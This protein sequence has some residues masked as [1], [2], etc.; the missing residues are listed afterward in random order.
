VSTYDASAGASQRRATVEQLL[1]D[2]GIHLDDYGL[3]EHPRTCPQCSHTRKKKSA[4]CLSVKID[5]DGACWKCSHCGWSG[6]EKGT[7]NGH[8]RPELPVHLYH[9]KDGELQFRKV[10][11][12]PGREPKCW[13]ERPD[14]K[15]GWI[16]SLSKM[17]GGKKVKVVD[18]TIL[19][20]IDMIEEAI[21]LGQEIAVV[22]GESD[23][24]ALWAIGIPA[25]TSPHGAAA[26]RDAD[27]KPVKKYTPKWTR[28]HSEQLKGARIVVL[29]DNDEPGYKHAEVTC[30]L[31]VGVAE[32]VRRLDLKPHWPEIPEGGDVRDWLNKGGGTREKLDALMAAAPAY[33]ATGAEKPG[34]VPPAGVED[35]YA[36]RPARAYIY[37]P[38]REL[39][40]AGSVNDELKDEDAAEWIAQNRAVVQMT[41][42]PGCQMLI[43][44]RVVDTGWIEKR[45]VTTF[46][47]YRP[48][49]IPLGD[50][51]KAGPWVDH[52]HKIYPADATHVINYLAHRVQRPHEK[53][54]HGIILGGP[55]GIGKDTLLEPAVRA[56]GPWNVHEVSPQQVLGRFNSFVKSVILRISEA[57]DL[58]ELNRFALYEHLKAYLATPPDVLRCDEKNLREHYVFNVMGVIITS[59]RK[60]SFHL[61]E[62]DRRHYVAWTDIT[63]ADFAAGYW[64]AI[65]K[66]YEN[67]GGYSNVAA[68]L[69]KLDISTFNPKQPPVKTPAF[70]DIVQANRAPENND[71]ADVI[72]KLGNPDAL[73]LIM[74]KHG[75]DH[76]FREWLDDRRNS[77]QLH[78]RL[79]ECGYVPVHNKDIKGGF[80]KLGGKRHMIYAKV[81]LS[82]HDRHKAAMHLK[83]NP[84]VRKVYKSSTQ[85]FAQW[86]DEPLW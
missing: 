41:W 25:T 56:V 80:W 71:L 49:T 69:T 83:A 47:L 23:A 76:D 38:T 46:N 31:S 58:G 6:P 12:V 59:N 79:G 3:G 13:L 37:L 22:E 33:E 18:D 1:R 62:D 57:R 72:E 21:A 84:P 40:S 75:A 43:K 70:W 5:A 78:H 27:G 67:E 28:R 7:G 2:N 34:Y 9:D 53:I 77:R 42:A 16:K 73:A 35:F 36:Y 29:N 51:S 30:K 8:A 32:T 85:G 10:R 15:G 48:P 64:D 44:D 26:T 52:V 45:G 68:Y 14:G 24:D 39:W 74:I 20:R 17:I 55:P 60:D 11:N 82:I 65:Y 63:Q 86:V 81:E 54:N 19:Y 50:A 66:W 61:P 4:Q